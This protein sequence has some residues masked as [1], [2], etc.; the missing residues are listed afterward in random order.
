MNICQKDPFQADQAFL[1]LKYKKKDKRL[2]YF[3]KKAKNKR[4]LTLTYLPIPQF[5][6]FRRI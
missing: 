4:E 2:I 3:L 5:L 1:K 6:E